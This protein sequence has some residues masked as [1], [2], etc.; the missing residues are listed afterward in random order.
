MSCWIVF[1][2]A[3]KDVE[4]LEDSIEDTQWHVLTIPLDL[5]A[6]SYV[7]EMKV[8]FMVFYLFFAKRLLWK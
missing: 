3:N 5:F 8:E 1:F 4:V 6:H 7:V 2:F